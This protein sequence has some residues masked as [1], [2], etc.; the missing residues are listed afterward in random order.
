MKQ[1]LP[2]LESGLSAAMDIID[3]L[4]VRA[5]ILVFLTLFAF[6][7]A[8]SNISTCKCVSLPTGS[9]YML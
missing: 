5:A 7:S 3:I 6:V 1:K 9:S 2:T 4:F 8:N